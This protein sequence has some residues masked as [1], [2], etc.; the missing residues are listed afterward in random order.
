M[1]P[2]R[3][4]DLPHWNDGAK[5]H[6]YGERGIVNALVTHVAAAPDFHAEVKK[7]LSAVVWADGGTPPWI[8]NII[9]VRVIVEISLAD[10]GNPDLMIVCDVR[11]VH[12][13]LV[14]VEA[15]A[16][17]YEFSCAPNRN[18]RDAG[19][20]STINGQLA[21]KYR[22]A[23]ALEASKADWN[24]IAE[25]EELHTRYGERRRRHLVKGEVR[26]VL[27]AYGL[28]GIPEERCYYVAFTWDDGPTRV[29]DAPIETRPSF[30]ANDGRPLLGTMADRYG[31]LG[32][33]NLEEHLKLG[34]E[35]RNACHGMFS[36]PV[37]TQ[38]DYAKW[39]TTPELG[40]EDA[41]LVEQIV[42]SLRE[43]CS[44]QRTGTRHS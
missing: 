28:I 21:L 40:P 35:Y 36:Q 5:V 32:Y 16:K 18:N 17:P 12:P 15:K 10:F 4:Y 44:G 42:A 23:R 33:G 20:S 31:W 14:F 39:K 43:V 41:T 29:F 25:P 8:A 13:Y 22:F 11:T 6:W 7:L 26:D 3:R 34:A 1:M 38:G 19:F 24:E 37:P 9:R 2:S 27:A 30:Q